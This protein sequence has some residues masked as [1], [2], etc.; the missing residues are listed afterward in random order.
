[1]THAARNNKKRKKEKKGEFRELYHIT[2][3]F[4]VRT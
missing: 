4:K 3:K 1:M 2:G